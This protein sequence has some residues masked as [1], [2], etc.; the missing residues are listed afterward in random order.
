MIS[1]SSFTPKVEMDPKEQNELHKKFLLEKIPHITDYINSNREKILE[2]LRLA[3]IEQEQRDDIM[4]KLNDIIINIHELERSVQ[5][6]D[7]KI[8]A[9][10]FLSDRLGNFEGT[11]A[12]FTTAINKD[13]CRKSFL[14]AIIEGIDDFHEY[15][16]TI[17][18][19]G[20]VWHELDSR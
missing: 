9:N 6:H 11:L 15:T 19:N 7:Q 5:N 17:L 8:S 12:M 18:K 2:C 13:S 14:E 20:T 3:E 10:N 16:D 1:D 4:N